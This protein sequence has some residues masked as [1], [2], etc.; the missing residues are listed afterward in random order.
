VRDVNDLL[1]LVHPNDVE[2]DLGVLHPEGPRL[3][4]F[5]REEH[6]SIAGE[7]LPEHKSFCAFSLGVGDF[8]V[9]GRTVRETDLDQAII[10]FR[11]GRLE[12]QPTEDRYEQPPR[13]HRGH[14]IGL[15][16]GSQYAATTRIA[17]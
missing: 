17:A 7:M 9:D 1:F 3:R 8:R 15:K 2:R 16:E 6:S 10:R 4:L 12:E 13:P 11:D 5:K 14:P